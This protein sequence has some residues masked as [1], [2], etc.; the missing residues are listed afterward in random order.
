MVAAGRWLVDVL[1][2]GLQRGIE[3]WVRVFGRR[4]DAVGDSW[5]V[6]PIAATGAV[7]P[8]FY[9]D[10]AKSQGLTVRAPGPEAGLLDAFDALA[11]PG[12]EPGRVQAEVARFY[13]HTAGFQLDV[14]S[15]WSWLFRPFGW[16]LIRLVSRRMQQLNIPL[17][18]LETS[19][20]MT[21][22]VLV[23]EDP[24]TG[25]R[26][27]TGWLRTTLETGDVVY[28]GL[29][30]VATPP[31]APGPC[32]KVVFPVPRGNTTV[33]LRPEVQPDGSFLLRSG[34]RGFGDSGFYRLV[35]TGEGRFRAR[36]I[37][38]MKETIH[39]GLDRQG[40][41]R[42]EHVFRFFRL[43]ILRLDY[44]IVPRPAPVES[45]REAPCP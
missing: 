19:R 22:E 18:P 25:R 7:G 39:V 20:G 26:A 21:S 5:L 27:Y 35:R 24:A 9:R 15:Q 2:T 30:A 4:I 8:G 14:W 40:V 12:F 16:L 42:T 34:G 38:A 17:S 1:G 36:Y 32:V 11:G 43:E 44:K 31:R 45:G 6:G 41:L 23:L 3:L 37:P 28:A 29:Y 10:F 33:F 13:E